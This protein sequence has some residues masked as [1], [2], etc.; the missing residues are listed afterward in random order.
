IGGGKDAGTP[1]AGESQHYGTANITI[2]FGKVICGSISTGGV[3]DVNNTNC[4]IGGGYYVKSSGTYHNCTVNAIGADV[5]GRIFGSND[6]DTTFN[7]ADSSGNRVD[8][9]NNV[10]S[11][12]TGSYIISGRITQERIFV[13]AG[14]D[15]VV[16]INLNGAN[17]SNSCAFEINSGTVNLNLVGTNTLTSIGEYAG[18]QQNQGA[19]LLTI[20][21]TGNLTAK[22]GT[23]G[24]GGGQAVSAGSQSTYDGVD[25]NITIT[26]G[27][28]VANGM[29]GSDG[30]GNAKVGG[31]ANLTINGGDITSTG[32]TGFDLGG[33]KSTA[34]PGDNESQHYGA[35][36]I[37]ITDGTVTCGSYPDGGV[38]D[39]D[40]VKCQIG[41]GYYVKNNKSYQNS[42]VTITNGV[43]EGNCFNGPTGMLDV[44]N[45][46]GQ[47]VD[48]I[49]NVYTLCSGSYTIS[50][51]TTR[52]RIVAYPADGRK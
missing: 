50:G 22:G 43:V 49:N 42:T 32:A 48:A 51:S 17:I 47:R 11:L 37:N 29:G 35:A 40:N 27:T 5:T 14:K 15:N 26:G 7:V 9:V 45:S 1:V 30:K 46:F 16:N 18:L 8:A 28:I 19:G 12:S 2:T 36:N 3:A 44:K 20:G 6:H 4:Q 31:A 13:D 33:G 21:G 25:A 41:G 52:E 38:A 34:T 24:I 23:L 39:A 10:Y